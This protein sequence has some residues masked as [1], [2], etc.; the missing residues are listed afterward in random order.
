MPGLFLIFLRLYLCSGRF[1]EPLT[2]ELV[3]MRGSLLESVLK[4]VHDEGGVIES[5]DV[6]IPMMLTC[7]IFLD[8][9]LTAGTFMPYRR[10][11]FHCFVF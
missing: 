4:R 8:K 10:S 11:L 7:Q 2:L 9:T 3:E 6:S 5:M 1:G